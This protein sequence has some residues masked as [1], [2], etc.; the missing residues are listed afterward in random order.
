MCGKR[1]ASDNNH[2]FR[3]L[4]FSRWTYKH[5]WVIFSPFLS[6]IFFCKTHT[7]HLRAI[8]VWIHFASVSFSIQMVFLFLPVEGFTLIGDFRP[9]KDFEQNKEWKSVWSSKMMQKWALLIR[10][11]N[12]R[13]IIKQSKRRSNIN[14]SL[15]ISIPCHFRWLQQSIR[16][17]RESTRTINSY[18]FK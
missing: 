8:H 3:F 12:R 9:I 1:C 4:C 17:A 13:K 18:S 2:A 10:V 16:A 7:R 11:I 15:S 14:I 6:F 5:R